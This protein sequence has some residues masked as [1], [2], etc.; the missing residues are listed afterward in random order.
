MCKRYFA[1]SPIIL[2]ASLCCAGTGYATLVN[3][4]F[5]SGLD[6]WSVQGDVAVESGAAVLG[7]DA[8]WYSLLFQG[9]ALEPG[10][11]TLQFDFFN[12]LSGDVPDFALGPDY[13][14]ASLYFTDDLGAFDLVNGVY[15]DAIGLMDMDFAGLISSSGTITPVAGMDGWYR[16]SIGFSNAYAYAIP[17]FEMMDFNFVD[18]DSGVGVD[19]VRIDPIIPEPA[20]ALLFACGLALRAAWKR[21]APK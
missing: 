12:A 21:R 19:N 1:M 20:T 6:G 5:S 14:L 8:E 13:F 16:Y 17:V 2:A 15:D 4:D 18:N 3:G 9:A 7:D 11:Y 10:A